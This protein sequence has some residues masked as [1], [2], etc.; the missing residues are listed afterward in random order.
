MS[1]NLANRDNK[2]P[3]VTFLDVSQDASDLVISGKKARFRG[4]ETDLVSTLP[5]HPVDLFGDR[6]ALNRIYTMLNQ[7]LRNQYGLG[8]FPG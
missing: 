5:T 4:I 1:F 2:I 8:N 3:T 6:P 7:D